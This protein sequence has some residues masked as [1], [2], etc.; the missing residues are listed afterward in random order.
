MGKVISYVIS[1]TSQVHTS[2]Q[3]VTNTLD[4]LKE[5]LAPNQTDKDGKLVVLYASNKD[6]QLSNLGSRNCLETRDLDTQETQV[7][8]GAHHM[9]DFFQ[10]KNLKSPSHNESAN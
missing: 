10:E 8:R 6:L 9:V 7:S 1:G 4:E 5:K 2:S 3:N